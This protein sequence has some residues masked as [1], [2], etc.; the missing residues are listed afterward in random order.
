MGNKADAP[1]SNPSNTNNGQ[2]KSTP[3]S[4]CIRP[5]AADPTHW[6][7]HT[8]SHGAADQPSHP[9]DATGCNNKLTPHDKSKKPSLNSSSS[10]ADRPS[11]GQLNAAALSS[12]GKNPLPTNGVV[13]PTRL[14][15]SDPSFLFPSFGSPYYPMMTAPQ[16]PAYYSN[17]YVWSVPFATANPSSCSY[18][19]TA[20]PADMATPNCL[21]SPTTKDS[22]ESNTSSTAD[23]AFNFPWMKRAANYSLSAEL[24]SAREASTAVADPA[25]PSGKRKLDTDASDYLPASKH[26]F[27]LHEGLRSTAFGDAAMTWPAYNP[28]MFLPYNLSSY[29]PEGRGPAAAHGMFANTFLKGADNPAGAAGLGLYSGFFPSPCLGVNSR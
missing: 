9:S 16:L 4:S 25:V 12:T 10:S 18:G 1:D 14:V 29:I 26:P 5:S 20:P 7:H 11:C 24:Q 28:S 23:Q 8:P 2:K 22:L 21:R 27:Y 15:P 6:G 13:D 19:W 17:P 3:S